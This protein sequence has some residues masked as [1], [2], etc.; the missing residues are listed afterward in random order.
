MAFVDSYT[1]LEFTNHS[2]LSE[3]NS[4]SVQMSDMLHTRRLVELSSALIGGLI[5]TVD[6][7]VL[8]Y[9]QYKRKGA[10]VDFLLTISVISI[11][12]LLCYGMFCL[13]DLLCWLG[14]EC[15]GVLRFWHDNLW[16]F[17]VNTLF[18]AYGYLIIVLI[19]DRY[20]AMHHPFF[21]RATSFR[22]RIRIWCI[23]ACL[24]IGA[25]CNVKWLI[26]KPYSKDFEAR[27]TTTW[28]KAL[29]GISCIIQ[30]FV[31]GL[32]MMWFSYKNYQKSCEINRDQERGGK[33]GIIQTSTDQGQR[34]HE[35]VARIC[36]IFTVTYIILNWPYG[37]YDYILDPKLNNDNHFIGVL[38]I[39]INFNQALYLQV[40][41]FIF[42]Y[43]SRLYR[44][45]LIYILKYPFFTIGKCFG[46][47]KPSQP[48]LRPAHE[49][50]EPAMI[51][52]FA[53]LYYSS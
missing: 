52:L 7:S 38:F 24:L 22:S 34:A 4:T 50:R 5:S 10:A 3:D 53:M 30:Y 19:I 31:C 12:I 18:C 33:L 36:V 28:Y 41:L 26:L 20:I 32:L 40:N 29:N 15:E 14:I 11:L 49:L 9:L 43:S 39:L 16:M 51:D 21:Y 23:L 35:I 8:V 27:L 2:L 46:F 37:I 25:L 6:L 47:Q 13:P 17:T 48:E 1:S 42:S 45:T 44:S